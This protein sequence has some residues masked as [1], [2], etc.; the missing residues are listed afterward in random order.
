MGGPEREHDARLI[1]KVSLAPKVV[2]VESEATQC[3]A[4]LPK[5]K[6][7]TVR[8]ACEKVDARGG[9][10]SEASQFLCKICC[11]EPRVARTRDACWS[12]STAWF[13]VDNGTN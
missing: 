12:D 7:K 5:E 6:Q 3:L 1:A 4:E 11:H 13:H 9:S 10:C 8:R 2:F